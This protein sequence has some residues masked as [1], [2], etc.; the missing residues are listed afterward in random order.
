[1]ATEAVTPELVVPKT[2]LNRKVLIVAG[3]AVGLIL[4]GGLA[5]LKTH[6]ADETSSDDSSES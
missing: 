4:A 1:M 2:P 6:S 5:F 3:A